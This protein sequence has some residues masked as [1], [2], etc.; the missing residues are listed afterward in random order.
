MMNNTHIRILHSEFQYYQSGG[1]KLYRWVVTS[2]KNGETE[3]EFARRRP[4]EN[5]KH[6][7]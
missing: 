7:E 6:I 1:G 4:G 3:S 5:I 2:V